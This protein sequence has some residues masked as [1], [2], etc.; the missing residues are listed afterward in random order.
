MRL[1]PPPRRWRS[2]AGRHVTGRAGP[3]SQLLRPRRLGVSEI[4]STEHANKYLSLVDLAGLWI[5]NRDPL[6]RV[7]N[8]SLFSRHV[9]LAHHRAQ[10]SLESTQKITEA[11]VPV[12]VLVD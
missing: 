10:P 4:G 11:A 2:Q 7:V 8:E 12:A 6:A 5:D 9:M 1:A 3:I